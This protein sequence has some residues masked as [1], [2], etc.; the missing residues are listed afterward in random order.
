MGSDL[1]FQGEQSWGW[2]GVGAVCSP[3]L[4]Y[5]MLVWSHQPHNTEQ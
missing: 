4:V 2:W 5:E 3:S 1:G